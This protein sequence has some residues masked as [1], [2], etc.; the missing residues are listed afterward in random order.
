MKNILAEVL[1]VEQITQLCGYSASKH[2]MKWGADHGRWGYGG[3]LVEHLEFRESP[4]LHTSFPVLNGPE[5]SQ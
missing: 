4:S 5:E 1:T 3:E 2:A